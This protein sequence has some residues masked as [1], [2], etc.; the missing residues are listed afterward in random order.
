MATY[1]NETSQVELL[2]RGFFL[3]IIF[4]FWWGKK[5]IS[6]LVCGTH[7]CF[8]RLNNPLTLNATSKLNLWREF[9]I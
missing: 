8:I 7:L 1:F 4:Q 2:T 6:G 5:R 9:L 3:L